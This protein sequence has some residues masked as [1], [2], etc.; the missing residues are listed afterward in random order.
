[1]VSIGA[2]VNGAICDSSIDNIVYKIF[3]TEAKIANFL[4]IGVLEKCMGLFGNFEDTWTRP[5][6]EIGT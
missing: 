3:E 1:M 4:Q 5:Y 6:E 2:K